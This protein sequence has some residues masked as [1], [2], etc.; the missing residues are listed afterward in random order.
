M[1]EGEFLLFSFDFR[2]TQHIKQII[3]RTRSIMTEKLKSELNEA[4]RSQV[5]YLYFSIRFGLVNSLDSI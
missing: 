5:Y 3:G 4:D 1:G 2:V